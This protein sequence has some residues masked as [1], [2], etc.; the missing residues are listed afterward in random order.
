[1]HPL[2]WD[3]VTPRSGCGWERGRGSSVHTQR[4]SDPCLGHI[5]SLTFERRRRQGPSQSQ[6]LLRAV[7][8]GDLTHRKERSLNVV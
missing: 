3:R 5:C 7:P 1:M 8:A 2:G 6:S 4:K